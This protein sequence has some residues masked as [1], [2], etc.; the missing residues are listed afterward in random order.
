LSRYTKGQVVVV[1]ASFSVDG[2][3]DDPTTVTFKVKDPSG[4]VGTFVYGI[5]PEVTRVS[6]GVYKTEIECDESGDFWYRIEADGSV[7]DATEKTFTVA[8]SQF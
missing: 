2:E 3:L 4:N 6:L 1:T 8:N 7:I 5:D